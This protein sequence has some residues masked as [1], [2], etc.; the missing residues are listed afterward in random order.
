MDPSS[1]RRNKVLKKAKR[2]GRGKKKKK[3]KGSGSGD[4]QEE[5]SSSGSSSTYVDE[6]GL[7]ENERKL[8]QIWSRYPGALSAHSVT[9]AK[10]QLVTAAGTVWSVDRTS[11][12]PVMTQYVRQCVIPGTSAPMGQEILSIAQAI[13]GLILGKVASSLDI[14]CQRLKS[15]ESLSRGNHWSVGRQLELI[16]LDQAGLTDEAEAR[17][18]AKQAREE[19]R[20]R[21]LV[22]VPFGGRPNEANQGNKGQGKKGGKDSKG[23]KQGRSEDQNKRKGG[24]GKREDNRG[25]QKKDKWQVEE[26]PWN[27]LK[28]LWKSPRGKD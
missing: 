4:S 21:G 6:G 10:N 8:K 22:K 15:L 1:K 18:A 25:W 17:A 13:D 2:L 24:D 20:L 26:G 5:S 19:E 16:R 23:G 3:K 12:P 11:L 28:A 7:F 9:E 27:D 14:L